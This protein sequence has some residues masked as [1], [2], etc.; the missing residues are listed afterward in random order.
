[1][2]RLLLNSFFFSCSVC[3][4]YTLMGKGGRY[5]LYVLCVEKKS[6]V[7]CFV[8]VLL[9]CLSDNSIKINRNAEISLALELYNRTLVQ[10]RF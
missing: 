4:C 8:K 1:M 7:L 3:V 2:I 5:A 6:Q 9:N 10:N